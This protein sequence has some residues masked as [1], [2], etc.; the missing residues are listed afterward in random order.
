MVLLL[1]SGR[2]QVWRWKEQ[3]GGRIVQ[4]L[5]GMGAALDWQR[6]VFT[7]DAPRSAAVSDAF[8]RLHEQGAGA[9]GRGAARAQPHVHRP[10]ASCIAARAW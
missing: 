5:R 6:S 2:A 7:M 4:Q 10:Q 9:G 8:V 1:T 3:Y